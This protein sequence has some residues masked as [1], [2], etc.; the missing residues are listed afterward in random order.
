MFASINLLPGGYIVSRADALGMPDEEV[1]AVNENRAAPLLV[2][3]LQ[4]KLSE[5]ANA[6]YNA[7]PMGRPC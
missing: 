2:Q 5:A 7:P 6:L 4:A 1:E 3:K